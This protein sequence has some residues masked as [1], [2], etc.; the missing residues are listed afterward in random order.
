MNAES[1]TPRIATVYE[2]QAAALEPRL[3]KLGVTWST[4]QL[5]STIHSAEADCSQ[6]VIATRLGIT[7]AT[8]SESVAAH[9]ASGLIAQVPSARDKR[10]KTLALTS[11]AKKTMEKILREVQVVEEA[12]VRGVAENT[13]EST[14]RVLDRYRKNLEK[15]MAESESV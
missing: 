7:P 3:E 13:L 12:M 2:L 10:V 8:L 4:F 9:V 15:L 5:L 6:A 11:T 1:V 14:N